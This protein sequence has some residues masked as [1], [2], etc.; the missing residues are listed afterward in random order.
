MFKLDTL[1]TYKQSPFPQN[2]LTLKY[3]KLQKINLIYKV[4]AQHSPYFTISIF[5][6]RS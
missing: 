1:S 5:T 6:A 3:R 4:Y 2:L